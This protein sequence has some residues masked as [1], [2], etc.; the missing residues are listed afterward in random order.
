MS[1]KGNRRAESKVS[2]GRADRKCVR[3]C[4]CAPAYSSSLGVSSCQYACVCALDIFS[5]KKGRLKVNGMGGGRG[6][7]SGARQASVKSMDAKSV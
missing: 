2:E 5:R 1:L 6:T 7:V 3:A 4:A